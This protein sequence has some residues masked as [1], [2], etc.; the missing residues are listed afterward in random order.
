MLA[1][2]DERQKAVVL[3]KQ[4]K[5]YSEIMSLLP[6][7]QSSLSLWLRNIQLTRKQTD[8][9]LLRKRL[10][11][12]KGGLAKRRFRELQERK[13]VDEALKELKELTKRELWL[14]GI[15]AY[16]CEGSKQRE[17]N[18]SQSVVFVNS[19]PFLLNLFV[20]WIK[21]I[22]LIK[23]ENIIYNLNIHETANVNESI[24]Y[25]SKVLEIGTENFGKSSIK[26]HSILTKRKNIGKNYYGLMRIRI[27]KSTNLNRKIKGWVMGINNLI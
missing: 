20:K 5:S 22:C 27:R 21:E 14:L 2:L 23:D 13:I 4:G 25:W 1:K 11:Q 8:R 17:G 15:I 18:I 7:S 24:N 26:R 12:A 16:W 9:L 6:V 3:R 19:D 10:G